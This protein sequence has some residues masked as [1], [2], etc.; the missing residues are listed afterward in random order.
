MDSFTLENLTPLKLII[1]IPEGEPITVD[2]LFDLYD[3]CA[4][5]DLIVETAAKEGKLVK[6]LWPLYRDCLRAKFPTLPVDKLTNRGIDQ[7]ANKIV[8]MGIAAKKA[9]RDFVAQE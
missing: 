7:L 3:V 4:A 9:D 6:D 2:L 5:L 8:K 1:P